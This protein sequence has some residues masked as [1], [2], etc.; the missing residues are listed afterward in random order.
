M[1]QADG[2]SSLLSARNVTLDGRAFEL[3]V[4]READGPIVGLVKAAEGVVRV[5]RTETPKVTAPLHR[6]VG[7]GFKVDPSTPAGEAA[8][9][10]LLDYL[11][12]D[13]RNLNAARLLRFD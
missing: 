4:E 1:I 3:R 7:E 10:D 11:E 2:P 5:P 6:R 8:I 12:A 13:L 9:A